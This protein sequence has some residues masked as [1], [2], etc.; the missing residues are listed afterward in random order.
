[1]NQSGRLFRPDLQIP[2]ALVIWR[3]GFSTVASDFVLP[4]TRRNSSPVLYVSTVPLGIFDDTDDDEQQ[5]NSKRRG[6]VEYRG[7]LLL[8]VN[9]RSR[10]GIGEISPRSF[11]D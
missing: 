9:L 10:L 8:R 1:M 5:S 6:P 7:S 2:D 11:S 3:L 4:D